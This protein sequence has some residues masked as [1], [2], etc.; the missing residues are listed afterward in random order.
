MIETLN[1]KYQINIK[2]FQIWKMTVLSS[3]LNG[4]LYELTNEHRVS[5]G[6]LEITFIV[7]YSGTI[8]S[9][10]QGFCI[11]VSKITPGSTQ[12]TSFTSTT[13]TASPSKTTTAQPSTTTTTKAASSTTGAQSTTTGR[14]E[15]LVKQHQSHLTQHTTTAKF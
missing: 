4:M 5:P 11:H 14:V 9:Y 8:N 6:Q 12:P 1:C 15:P 2:S 10:P 3:S 13:T 7:D